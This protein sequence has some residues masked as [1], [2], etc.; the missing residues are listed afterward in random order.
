LND[1][2]G[3]AAGRRRRARPRYPNRRG[4]QCEGSRRVPSSE[5]PQ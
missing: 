5:A 2:Q 1:R 3:S 4:Q